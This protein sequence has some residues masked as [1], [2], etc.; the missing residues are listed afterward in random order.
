MNAPWGGGKTTVLQLLQEQLAARDDVL[1][2]Y[3]SPWEY[4]RNTDT[5]AS[6]IGAVLGRLEGEI[7]GDESALESVRRRLGELRERI[8]LTKGGQTGSHVRAH[9]DSA[10]R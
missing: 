7:R 2:V 3:V 9:H 1:V 6:L 8:N 5:K 10:E 4:D